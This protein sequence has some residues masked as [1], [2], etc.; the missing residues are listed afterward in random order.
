[1]TS[2]KTQSARRRY[3]AYITAA[4]LG[5]LASGAALLLS[6]LLIFIFKLPV[7]YGDIFALVSFGAGCLVSGL[8]VGIIKRQK[9]LVSG[10]KAALLLLFPM[11]L[12]SYLAGNL[13]GEDA[14]TRFTAAVICGAAGG[15]IGVNRNGGF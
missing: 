15:V 3:G 11:V 9:G 13:T 1:M 6:S 2:R 10:I 4:A 8:T 5:A 7:S 14:L 12:I